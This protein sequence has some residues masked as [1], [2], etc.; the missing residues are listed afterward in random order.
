MNLS[1]GDTSRS[2]VHLMFFTNVVIVDDSPYYEI[3]HKYD[4]VD[5]IL[6]YYVIILYVSV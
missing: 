6:L 2:E 4:K 1:L 5:Y 3:Q